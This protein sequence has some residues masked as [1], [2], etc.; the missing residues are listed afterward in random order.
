ML[1]IKTAGRPCIV[2]IRKSRTWQ[3]LLVLP[4]VFPYYFSLFCYRVVLVMLKVK[5]FCDT[6]FM[7]L[8]FR[9]SCMIVYSVVYIELYYTNMY[10][11]IQACMYEC[12]Y[13]LCVCVC[14]C[15]CVCA[16]VRVRVRVRVRMCM[17]M[18]VRTYICTCVCN[19]MYNEKLKG[20]K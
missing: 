2:I 11:Y 12:M 5:Y 7:M 10:Q 15:V 13:V 14:V 18:C 3:K 19:S 16:R 17:C 4:S 8:C 20:L 1:Y 9:P 6:R